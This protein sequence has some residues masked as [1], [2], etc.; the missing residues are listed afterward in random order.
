MATIALPKRGRSDTLPGVPAVRQGLTWVRRFPV[1][2]GAVLLFLLIIPGI[3]ANQIA[4]HDYRIGDLDLVKRPP[5]WIGDK[6]VDQTVVQTVDRRVAK[7]GE[8][9]LRSAER[10]IYRGTATFLEGGADGTVD[11]GDKVRVV[12]RP[13]GN[14]SYVQGTDKQGRDILSRIIAGSRVSLTVSVLA[15]ALGDGMGVALDLVAAYSDGI[16]DSLIMRLVDIMLAFS[17]ILLALVLV[18]T[19]KPGLSTVI[20]MITVLLWARYARVVRGEALAIRSRDSIGRAQVAGASNFRIMFRHIFP[21]LMNTAV[22]L[23]T[24]EVGHVIILESTR[25]FLGA[26]ITRPTPAWGVMVADGRELI[27]AA[28]WIF[29]PCIAIVL[30]VLSMNLLGNWLRD[31]LD[32]KLRTY[33]NG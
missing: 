6:I 21:N 17:G 26:G 1:L 18:A 11:I 32:P 7:Q 29:F 31:K 19:W 2:P 5:T 30:T 14:W 25:S 22:V 15:I 4:P 16:V 3:F 10:R 8:I 23:A 20:T 27:V 13:R 24:L 9:T 33:R 28:W 12:I